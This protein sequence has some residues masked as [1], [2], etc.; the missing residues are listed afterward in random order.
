MTTVTFPRG[1]WRERSTYGVGSASLA[2]IIQMRIVIPGEVRKYIVG[3]QVDQ[4]PR[5]T[6]VGVGNEMDGGAAGPARTLPV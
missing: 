3:G 2:Y 4:H 1:K 5:M 6:G